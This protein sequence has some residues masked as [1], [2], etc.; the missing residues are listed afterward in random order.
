MLTI[1]WQSMSSMWEVRSL[2]S[3][4]GLWETREQGKRKTLLITLGGLFLLCDLAKQRP[5]SRS[6]ASFHTPSPAPGT[7]DGLILNPGGRLRAARLGCPMSTALSLINVRAHSQDC[8]QC[9]S[10]DTSHNLDV[11]GAGIR[12]AVGH[13]PACDELQ[14]EV[15]HS[16]H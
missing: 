15:R 14:R 5:T 3:A 12:T 9:T 13:L 1:L 7:L 6:Y 4:E 10:P 11:R 16:C 8:C 2:Q